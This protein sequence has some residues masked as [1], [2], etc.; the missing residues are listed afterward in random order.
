M[1]RSPWSRDGERE[2]KVALGFQREEAV[3]VV[4]A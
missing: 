4:A 2:C 3:V 1:D